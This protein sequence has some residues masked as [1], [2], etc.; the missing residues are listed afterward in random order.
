M[1][2][3]Y[4]RHTLHMWTTRNNQIHVWS[5]TLQ[6]HKY[7]KQ[8]MPSLWQEMG[9]KYFNKEEEYVPHVQKNKQ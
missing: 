4:C 5:N 7:P 8:I 3:V 1:K 6:R 9:N 2:A